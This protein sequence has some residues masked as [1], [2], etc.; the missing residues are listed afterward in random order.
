MLL[1]GDCCFLFFVFVLFC[2][3]MVGREEN[4]SV[5]FKSKTRLESVQVVFYFLHRSSGKLRIIHSEDNLR[6]QKSVSEQ[7]KIVHPV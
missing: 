1:D 3:Q 7:L 4:L 2:F 6:I 5:I